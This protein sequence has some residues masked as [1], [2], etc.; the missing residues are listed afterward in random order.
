MAGADVGIQRR[1]WDL[2]RRAASFLRMARLALAGA[3]PAQL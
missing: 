3:A 1:P 2:S